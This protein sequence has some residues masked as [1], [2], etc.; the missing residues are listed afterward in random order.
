ME[1]VIFR[2]SDF[3]LSGENERAFS[4]YGLVFNSD[5]VPMHI[6]DDSM[7]I[8]EVVERI[9]PDSVAEA[10]MSDVIAA[11]NHNFDK[12]MGR[13]TSGTLQI[14]ADDRGIKYRFEIPETSYGNDLMVIAKRGDVAGSSFVFSMDW[15]QG[16]DVQERDDGKIQA[17]VKKITKIHE[18]GP[19]IKPAY[20]ETTAENRSDA[21][22]EAIGNFLKRKKEEQ[23]R[24]A[25]EAAGTPNLSM[26]E[27]L[28]MIK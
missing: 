23:D 3:A 27:K 12:V 5:S 26:A 1:R 6:W 16:Y 4:G 20:P 2:N 9:T 11:Y 21:L 13:T 22:G 25:E 28:L 8:V 17:T 18:M 10:D 24:K 19:V 15:E 7:G 14:A